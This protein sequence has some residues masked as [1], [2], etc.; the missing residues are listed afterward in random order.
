MKIKVR[1]VAFAFFVFLMVCLFSN[2]ILADSSEDVTLKVISSKNE[3]RK[4]LTV[5]LTVQYINQNLYNDRNFISYHVYD[6]KGNELLW[7]GK[8]LPFTIDKEGIAKLKVDINLKTEVDSFDVNFLKISFDIVDEKNEYWYS[9]NT[10]INLS[11]DTIFVD[12]G[13]AK[14][15]TGTLS[16]VIFETP[17]IFGIN[18]VCCILFICLLFRLKKSEVFNS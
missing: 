1:N 17:V 13:L 5:D 8:R 18:L 16:S 3:Y 2:I 7:E 6:K 9:T 12:L 10:D 14:R 11:S 4:E 15:F